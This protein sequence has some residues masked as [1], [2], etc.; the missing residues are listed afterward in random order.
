[1]T[2]NSSKS[3]RKQFAVFRNRKKRALTNETRKH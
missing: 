1:L 2:K 3:R